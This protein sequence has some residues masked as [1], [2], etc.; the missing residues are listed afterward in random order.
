METARQNRSF[1]EAFSE[2]VCSNAHN[3]FVDNYDTDRFG[4]QPAAAARFETPKRLAAAC[5]RR[6]GLT[7][8]G[9]FSRIMQR[10]MDFVGPYLPRIEKLYSRLEDAESKAL[11]VHVLAYRTLGYRRIKLP[12]NTPEMWKARKQFEALSWRPQSIESG[13]LGWK[14]SLLDL[15]DC[16]LPVSLYSVPAGAYTQFGLQQYRCQCEP[17]AIEA[18]AGD[19]VIDAGGCWGDT[20]LYFAERV[21]EKGRVVTLEFVP[22]NV[23]IMRTN[24]GLNPALNARI[25][26]VERALLARSGE[27]FCYSENGPATTVMKNGT[28]H[29]DKIAVSISVD[30]LVKERHLPRVDFIKMDIEGAELSALKG[31]G[32]TLRRFKPKLAVCVYHRLEDFFDIPDY[33]ESLNLNYRFFLRHFTIYAEETVL[34]ARAD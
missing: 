19:C 30:D 34:F 29:A 24:L 11:L 22:A 1:I 20:A 25:E 17:R 18:S 4:R 8:V 15:K 16:G 21:G 6:F 14:L 26:V 5:V 32:E 10:A 13:F 27:K 28:D 2:E 31:A 3:Y 23:E 9:Y 7:G 33:L 12:L